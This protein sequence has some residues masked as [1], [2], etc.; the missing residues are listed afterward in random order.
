MRKLIVSINVTLDGFMAGPAGELD[1]HFPHWNEEMANFAY[2]QL[3]MMDSIL[4][5]RVTYQAMASYWP[6]E[7]NNTAHGL[8]EG[9]YASMMNNYAKIVFSRTLRTVEWRNARLVKKDIGKEV[10]ALKQQPGHN[11]IVFGSGSIV[12]KLTQLDLVDEYVLWVHPITLGRG[13][14]LFQNIRHM[15]ALQLLR[16]KA[17]S[18]GVVILYYGKAPRTVNRPA[19]RK[20]ALVRPIR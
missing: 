19:Q 18:S 9:N 11:M 17:F 10:L 20:H 4:L 7:A 15:P 12:S 16:T 13:V 14:P 2:E 1:W 3:C 6:Y 5:G 8:K